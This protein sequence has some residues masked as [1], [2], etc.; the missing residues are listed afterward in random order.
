MNINARIVKRFLKPLFHPFQML[1]RWSVRNA[2][3]RMWK[4]RFPHSPA[5]C[6]AV[7]VVLLQELFPAAHPNPV[8]PEHDLPGAGW[9][10]LYI[11]AVSLMR[12]D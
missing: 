11:R 12:F 8:S 7:P 1:T 3:V 5:A 9:L 4:N 6:Q 2:K 10:L